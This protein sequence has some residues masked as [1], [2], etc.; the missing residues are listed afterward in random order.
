MARHEDANVP[1]RFL[2]WMFA[3]S[4]MTDME[5]RKERLEALLGELEDIESPDESV[6]LV[7]AHVLRELGRTAEANRVAGQLTGEWATMWRVWTEDSDPEPHLE[8]T[9]LNLKELCAEAIAHYNASIR[10][11]ERLINS[12]GQVWPASAS[13]YVIPSLLELL[14]RAERAGVEVDRSEMLELPTFDLVKILYAYKR[15]QI[16]GMTEKP[17]S[18]EHI[19]RLV[20]YC[21][22]QNISTELRMELEAA[23]RDYD[24]E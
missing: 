21:L 12:A 13:L 2:R 18:I 3:V 10:M 4:D 19:K 14:E 24:A 8:A 15:P 17:P 11:A 16:P 9:R 23:L 22:D 20:R 5:N 6:E 1:E 7:K